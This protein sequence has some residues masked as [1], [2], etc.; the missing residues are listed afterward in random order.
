QSYHNLKVSITSSHYDFGWEGK[1]NSGFRNLDYYYAS[2]IKKE[3][4]LYIINEIFNV[5]TGATEINGEVILTRTSFSVGKKR[6]DCIDNEKKDWLIQ[7]I[8]EQYN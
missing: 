6:N 5:N 2:D 4:D 7:K 1:S 8:I 3:N